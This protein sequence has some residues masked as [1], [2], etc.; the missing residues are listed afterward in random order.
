MRHI[1]NTNGQNWLFTNVFESSSGSMGTGGSYET[2]DKANMMTHD[3][4]I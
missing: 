1:L 3:N 4:K 2:Q